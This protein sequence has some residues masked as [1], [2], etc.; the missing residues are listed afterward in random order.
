MTGSRKSRMWIISTRFMTTADS[1][2][3]PDGLPKQCA[4]EQKIFKYIK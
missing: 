1:K 4:S 2:R 3:F